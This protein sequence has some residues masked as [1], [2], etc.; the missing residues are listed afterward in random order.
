[1][2]KCSLN[3]VEINI[4][5]ISYKMAQDVIYSPILLR[6]IA[7]SIFWHWCNF[8]V[9]IIRWMFMGQGLNYLKF[10]QLWHKEV[11]VYDFS[12][13]IICKC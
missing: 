9:K 10:V 12:M 5:T 4:Y 6:D 11:K 8:I 7:F 1:M 13:R 2:V 3:N